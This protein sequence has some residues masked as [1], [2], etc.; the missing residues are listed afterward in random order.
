[1]GYQTAEGGIRWVQDLNASTSTTAYPTATT[2]GKSLQD[3]MT[4]GVP[5]LRSA[6][7]IYVAVDYADTVGATSCNVHVYGLLDQG[8]F[9]AAPR[10]A[11]IAAMNKGQPIA[12]TGAGGPQF[13]ALRVLSTEAFVISGDNFTRFATRSLVPAG[14]APTVSTFI[15]FPLE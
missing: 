12:A 6:N 2:A 13:S 15:G 9:S 8:I 14:T 5:P 1:M 3:C 7:R 11:W 4:G 10:W